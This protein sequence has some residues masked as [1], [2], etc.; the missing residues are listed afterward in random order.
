MI[1]LPKSLMISGAKWELEVLKAAPG[2]ELDNWGS[3]DDSY[4]KI[5]IHLKGDKLWDF[6]TL[7]EEVLH[8]GERADGIFF[9]DNEKE[10]HARLK[11]VA[12]HI[13]RVLVENDLVK[14]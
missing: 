2:V 3:M 5:K 12:M 14:I 9:G 1:K 7:I 11:Q 4:L 10:A 8:A 6:H 13:A